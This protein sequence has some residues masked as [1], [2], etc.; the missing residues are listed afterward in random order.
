MITIVSYGGKTYINV[1]GVEGCVDTSRL[2]TIIN[3]IAFEL[4]KHIGRKHEAA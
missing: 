3:T 1:N 2:S 4:L